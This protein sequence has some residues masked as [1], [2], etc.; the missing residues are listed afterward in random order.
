VAQGVHAMFEAVK[1][2][3]RWGSDDERGALNL[4]TPETVLAASRLVQRGEVVSCGRDLAIAPTIDD[5]RP[6]QHMMLIA[7]DHP[8]GSGLPGFQ[9]SVDFL[10]IACHGMGISHIDALCHVFVDGLM[11]NGFAASEVRSVGAMRNSIAAAG[12]GIVGR[13]VLIDIPRLRGTSWL[14]PTDVVSPDE[15][16]AAI[17]MQHSDV[18]AGDIVIV[19]TGRDARRAASGPWSVSELGLAGL[20]AECVR[21]FAE[22]DVAVI[23][24]DGISD[25]LPPRDPLGD[26]P[27]PIHQCCIAA[28]GVHLIDNLNL[29]DLA[30]ACGRSNQWEF[31]FSVEALRAPRATGSPVNP[32]AIL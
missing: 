17:Q 29:V 6:P 5:P 21:W 2:W 7:G 19:N 22:R 24:S 30:A 20:A 31:L 15:L 1:S 8:E 16:E 10:G 26:W 4:I 12:N 3:G 11:Y 23:A 18:L 14:E 9:E 25:P 28:M 32:V 13:G 27:F